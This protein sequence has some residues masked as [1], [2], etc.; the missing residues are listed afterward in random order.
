MST[1]FF[2][3]SDYINTSKRLRDWTNEFQVTADRITVNP[4]AVRTG[5]NGIRVAVYAIPISYWQLAE[6]VFPG[7][8]VAIGGFGFRY[9]VAQVENPAVFAAIYDNTWLQCG[10]AINTNGTISVV[11]KDPA[12]GSQ[13][14]MLVLGNSNFALN[15]G[16][17]YYIEYKFTIQPSGATAEVRVNGNVVLSLTG[18]NTAPSG[19]SQYNVLRH[20]WLTMSQGLLAAPTESNWD[21]DDIYL[22]DDQ[23]AQNNDYIGPCGIY[24]LHALSGNGTYTNFTPLTGSDHGDMVKEVVADDNA[25]YNA[26]SVMGNKDSYNLEDL[27]VPGDIRV[28][29]S[30]NVECL[31]VAGVKAAGN[32]FR[33]GGNDYTG[34]PHSPDVNYSNEKTIYEVSPD[35]GVAWT[36]TEVNSMEGGLEITN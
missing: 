35:T 10:L 26:D 2:T 16:T 7:S 29:Q 19:N 36:P 5:I 34:P 3:G 11:S 4:L 1:L 32:L 27:P 18:L 33:I 12:F 25:S 8:N 14:L 22:L 31:D 20:G 15:A 21:Y 9:S 13:F 24:A 6:T 17:Y 30:I 28:L 23:G